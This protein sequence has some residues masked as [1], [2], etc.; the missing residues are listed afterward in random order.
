MKKLL[1]A[2]SVGALLAP[3]TALA[4]TINF[5]DG[6]LNVISD[7]GG[8]SP[9]P[10]AFSETD[11]GVT[12]TFVATNNLVGGPKFNGGP[13]LSNGVHVGGGGGSSLEF[14]MTVNSDVTLTGYS[15]GHPSNSVFEL[16]TPIFDLLDG[17][18]VLIDDG[19]IN[20]GQVVGGLSVA[21]TSGTTYTF[22]IN[23]GSAGT[24]GYFKTL[25]FDRAVV[26]VPAAL[27]LAAAGFGLLGLLGW[28]Q[29][30][31]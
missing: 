9:T 17:V 5:Q 12:F 20:P 26:P 14:T 22:D 1:L 4:G 23:Q 27:P 19:D 15:T 18:T 2:A 28:R 31:R 10:T 21:L 6:V 29:R 8:G 7:T 30:T 25:E 13:T 16:G 3:A 24:Q 11:M